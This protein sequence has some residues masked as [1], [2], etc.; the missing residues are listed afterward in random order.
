MG[1][2]KSRDYGGPPPGRWTTALGIVVMLGAAF[3]FALY[4]VSPT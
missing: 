2:D 1:Y 3:A 4:A